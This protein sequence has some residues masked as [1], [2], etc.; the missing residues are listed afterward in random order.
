MAEVFAGFVAGYVLALVS[1]PL[2]A[3]VL[4][5]LRAGGGLLAQLLPPGVSAVSVGVLLH[6]ALF[7]AWTAL[8]IILGLVLLAMRDAGGGMGSANAAFT[9]FVAGLVLALAAPIAIALPPLRRAAII[10]ALVAVGVFG[11][12]MPYL[13]EWSTFS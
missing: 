12:L 6:G 11:W 3:V 1:T 2:L 10:C 8:G 5:R 4:V 9:L 7:L 13:A